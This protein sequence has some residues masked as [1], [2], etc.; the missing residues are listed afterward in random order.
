MCLPLSKSFIEFLEKLHGFEPVAKCIV[1][2]EDIVDSGLG[3][4]YRPASL[5]SLTGRYDNPMPESTLSPA[6]SDYEFGYCSL[7]RG[8][9]RNRCGPGRD[10]QWALGNR[11]VLV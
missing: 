6:V 7:A 2:E 8:V 3:L 10:G 9:R 1:P 5:C 11:G 4:S